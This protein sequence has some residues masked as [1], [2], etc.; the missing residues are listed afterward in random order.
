MI[1]ERRMY[2]LRTSV[3]RRRRAMRLL[4]LMRQTSR[5]HQ[6]EPPKQRSLP[7]RLCLVPRQLHRQHP[8][9]ARLQPLLHHRYLQHQHQHQRQRQ[10]LRH[11]QCQPRSQQSTQ[12]QLSRF[13]T[14]SRSALSVIAT[15]TPQPKS[16]PTGS[17]RIAWPPMS[18][19]GTRKCDRTSSIQR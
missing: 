12:R 15:F 11:H 4:N 2:F 8:Y 7:N 3:A 18:H 5:E 14:R 16:P 19:R 10:Q 6:T 9:Q 17:R 13:V 1:R